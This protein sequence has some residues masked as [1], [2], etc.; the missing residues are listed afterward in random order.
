MSRLMR[1]HLLPWTACLLL[2]LLLLLPLLG[3]DVIVLTKPMF[4]HL[5][6][7]YLP[8]LLS[9]L[10]LSLLLPDLLLCQGLL[11]RFQSLLE[12]H[13]LGSQVRDKPD[14]AQMYD[15]GPWPFVL[16]T[17]WRT[18]TEVVKGLL[19]KELPFAILHPPPHH[20]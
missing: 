11:S 2:F 20:R 13:D 16:T 3:H 12:L 10:G 9:L 8:S 4:D 1:L 6:L 19:L 5:A 18:I 17:G 7:G 14:L 15:P